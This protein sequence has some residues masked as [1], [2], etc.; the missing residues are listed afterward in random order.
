M[1]GAAEP[2][3]NHAMNTVKVSP[4]AATYI[5]LPKQAM[6]PSRSLWGREGHSARGVE[7]GADVSPHSLT[8]MLGSSSVL[9]SL[10]PLGKMRRTFLWFENL[11]G[12]GAEWNL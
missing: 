7:E 4:V 8:D 3:Q 11:G 1:T 12:Q 2:S 9:V 5:P 6:R 10:R